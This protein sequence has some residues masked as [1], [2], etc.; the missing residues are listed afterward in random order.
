MLITTNLSI[1]QLKNPSDIENGR[2]YDRVLER[3]FP[4]ECKGKNRRYSNIR[5]DFKEMEALLGL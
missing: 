2:I 1:E 5:N 3:C 4:I